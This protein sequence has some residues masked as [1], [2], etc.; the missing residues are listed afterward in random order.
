[1]GTR[2]LIKLICRGKVIY[3]YNQFDS[4]PKGLGQNLVNELN[5][6]LAL[7][8]K[9]WLIE[10]ISSLRIVTDDDIP[11]NEDIDKLKLY[12]NLSVS[13]QSTSD[14]YCLLRET[15]GSLTKII[16]AGY[17]QLF[18]YQEGNIMIEYIYDIDL[19]N[20]IFAISYPSKFETSLDN[21]PANFIAS[22]LEQ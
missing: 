10:K 19:D 12:T 14:W 9:E 1:M 6:L 15:Q 4:Y 5:T 7:Y 16:E 11:S 18:D 21:I 13:N 20:N 8:G 22:Y 17:V 2:G 3:V